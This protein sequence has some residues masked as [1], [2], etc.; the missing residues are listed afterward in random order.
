MFSFVIAFA[1]AEGPDD[2]GGGVGLGAGVGVGDGAGLGGAG[3]AV[4]LGDAVV[5]N[6]DGLT[7]AD[8]EADFPPHPVTINRAARQVTTTRENKNFEICT[9]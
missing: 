1:G 9:C 7:L 3:G 2:A 8:M 4:E 5:G 6:G